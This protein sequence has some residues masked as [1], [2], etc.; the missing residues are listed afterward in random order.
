M[1]LNMQDL[2]SCSQ[3][4]IFMLIFIT[5]L[6]LSKTIRYIFLPVL[7]M[8]VPGRGMYKIRSEVGLGYQYLKSI[9][10]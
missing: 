6:T 8:G 7:E 10:N 3:T 2:I 1:C 5:D 4:D 9:Q